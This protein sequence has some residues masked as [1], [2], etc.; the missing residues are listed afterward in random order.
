MATRLSQVIAIEK[1]VKGKATRT[2]TDAYHNLAKSPLLSGISRTYQPKDDEADHLPSESTLVQIKTGAVVAGITEDLVRLFD[3]TLTKD[4]ANSVAKADVV[5]DGTTLLADVPVPY[6]LFLEKQL[7]DLNTFV[8][9]LPVLD[10]S[11]NWTYNT[12]SGAYESDTAQTTRTVS[13]TI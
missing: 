4:A 2:L 8:T 11:E 6:L 3:V 1:G 13:Y 9:K 10:P 5:E 12:V 7:V